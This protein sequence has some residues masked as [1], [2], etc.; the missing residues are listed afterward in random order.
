VGRIAH[1]PIGGIEF[2][3]MEIFISWGWW[4]FAL[5]GGLALLISILTVSYQAIRAA[6]SNPVDSLRYE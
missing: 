6:L 1:D 2:F 4:I 3:F 5:S